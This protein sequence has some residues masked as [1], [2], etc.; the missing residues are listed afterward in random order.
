MPL[1][2]SEGFHAG[3]L[4]ALAL[5]GLG[6][7]LA[8]GIA[9]LSHQRERAFSAALIYVLL[10]A[11]GALAMSILDVSP[12]DP[13]NDHALIE[14]VSEL[15]SAV[16]VFSAGLT[17]E[18]HVRKRSL[19]SVAILILVVM[20]LTVALIAVFGYY[21]M[22]LSFGAAVLLGAVLAPTDPVLAGGRRARAP[23]V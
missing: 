11:V 19:I 17:V 4:Y 23:G 22:G 3:G 15:A 10:G 13:L 14:R 9:A 8:V 18:R 16:A 5:L 12:I 20:P 1:A 6:L 21:A 7:A 2:L